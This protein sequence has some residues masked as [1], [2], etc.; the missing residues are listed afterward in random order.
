MHFSRKGRAYCIAVVGGFA[1]YG[2]RGLAV[3]VLIILSLPNAAAAA[4]FAN[5]PR[6]L[7]GVEP[8]LDPGGVREALL[9]RG[10]DLGGAY[11]G[12]VLG[13]PSGGIT[14]GM[15]YDG[16]LQ[17]YFT[18]DMEKLGFWKGLCFHTDFYQIHGQ[19]ITSENVGSLVSISN[20]EAFP[21]TRI[22]EFWLEQSWHQGELSVRLGQLAA[23]AEFL[24]AE[25]AGAFIDSTF[26]WTTLS[27]DNIPVGG[28]IYP[29]ATPGVRIAVSPTDKLTSKVA[30]YNGDPAGPC[31]D[32]LDPGQC[33]EHGFEFRLK[34]P[35]LLFA[36]TD[37]TYNVG[38][39]LPGTIKFG[40]WQHFGKFDS[41]RLDVNGGLRGITQLDPLELDG[42]YG[43]YVV[44]DQMI[45]RLP[46]SDDTTNGVSVFARVVGS[47]SDRNQIDT[48][49]D[50]GIVFTGMM[51]SRPNDVFGIGFAYSRI[52]DQASDFDRESGL[53]VVRDYEALIEIS[54]TA[55]IKPGWTLQPDFQYVLNPGGNVPD[56][57]GRQA[58]DDA[59]V[60]GART[61]IS[62]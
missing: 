60:V 42:N 28:P 56:N 18:A 14:Q 5:D 20:I 10:V 51:S 3:A 9:D 48:Y 1:R 30:I 35:P 50:G 32:D 38:T 40:G 4:C 22:F 46:G 25:S 26:G 44:L 27:S 54:Y 17:L 37:Y 61:T 55:E 59:T 15:V 23:D 45:L 47:P 29:I 19:G 31:P 11:I 7:Q 6:L 12:E 13:N 33:N 21:S 43:I 39:G 41:Q 57:T 49:V 53:A 58:V 34:D 36:E 62:F 52:S 16:L 24:I 8:L 2:S